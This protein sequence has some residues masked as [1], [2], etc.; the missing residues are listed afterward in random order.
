LKYRGDKIMAKKAPYT[1]E[2]LNPRAP[3]AKSGLLPSG[4]GAAGFIHEHEPGE[5][6]GIMAERSTDKFNPPEPLKGMMTGAKSNI[7][8]PGYALARAA[9]G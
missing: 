1:D 2:R 7:E 8:M 5:P 3:H 9:R 6:T 4:S